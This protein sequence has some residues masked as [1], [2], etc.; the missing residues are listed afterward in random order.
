MSDVLDQAKRIP[1]VDFVKIVDFH[2]G[3]M[4]LHESEYN[5]LVRCHE[6]LPEL[7]A[8]CEMYRGGYL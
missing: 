8:E 3:K 6:I 7:I 2:N 5:T 1:R 4:L